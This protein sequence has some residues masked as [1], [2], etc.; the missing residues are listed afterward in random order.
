MNVFFSQIYIEPGVYIPFSD[1]FIGKMDRFFGIYSKKI[2][3]KKKFGDPDT[4]EM[5]ISAKKN[6]KIAEISKFQISK[7]Y[8]EISVF[9]FLPFDIIEKDP[10]GPKMAVEAV[11]NSACFVLT[12][13]SKN[14]QSLNVPI[15]SFVENVAGD[16]AVFLGPIW[17]D[18]AKHKIV[19]NFKKYLERLQ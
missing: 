7:K 3:V 18:G 14:F 11:V 13:I 2:K 9:L 8:S 19:R 1:E 17:E 6:I 10:N 15:S 4:I 12:D 5:R 16:P